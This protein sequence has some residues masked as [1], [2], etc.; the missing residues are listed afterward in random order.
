[1]RF[2]EAS[3]LG[4]ED[5]IFADFNLLLPSSTHGVCKSIVGNRFPINFAKH[6][7]AFGYLRLK[8]FFPSHFWTFARMTYIIPPTQ[9]TTSSQAAAERMPGT[10]LGPFYIIEIQVLIVLSYVIDLPPDRAKTFFT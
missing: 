5:D 8:Q 6:V 3:F 7:F 2:E 1:L 9:V 10:P 4:A